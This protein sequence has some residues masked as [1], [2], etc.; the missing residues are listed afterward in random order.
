MTM[1]VER[2]AS[3]AATEA[4]PSRAP[5]A[6]PGPPR[7]LAVVPANCRFPDMALNHRLRALAGMGRVDVLS[8]YPSSFPPDVRDR[9]VVRRLPVSPRLRSAT[10]KSRVR[11]SARAPTT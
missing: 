11:S 10:W 7:I 4:S 2:I 5:H 6:G 9:V 3:P 1:G 8:C